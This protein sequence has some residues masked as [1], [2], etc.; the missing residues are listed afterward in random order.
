MRRGQPNASCTVYEKDLDPGGRRNGFSAE[1]LERSPVEEERTVVGSC[2]EPVIGQFQE[3]VHTVSLRSGI[4]RSDLQRPEQPVPAKG[5]TAPIR[6]N[7][8]ISLIAR[9][10]CIHKVRSGATA[11]IIILEC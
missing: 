5:E 9:K 1:R 10:E 6:G 8:K 11:D 7:P 4:P 2:K 3:R